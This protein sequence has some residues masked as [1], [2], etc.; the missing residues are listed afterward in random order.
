MNRYDVRFKRKLVLMC[1]PV[2]IL[3][4]AH[5]EGLYETISPNRIGLRGVHHLAIEWEALNEVIPSLN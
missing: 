1:Q 2:R 4:E 5:N 3:M